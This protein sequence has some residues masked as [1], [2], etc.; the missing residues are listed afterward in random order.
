ML[1]YGIGAYIL[2]R[3][4]PLSLLWYATTGTYWLM[5]ESDDDRVRRLVREELGD[6]Q[7][8]KDPNK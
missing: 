3:I 6:V 7:K 4:G 2:W 5:S 1:F 8:F